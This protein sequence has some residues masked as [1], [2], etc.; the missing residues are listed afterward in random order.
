MLGQELVNESERP[1]RTAHP[2]WRRRLPRLAG[3][4]GRSAGQPEAFPSCLSWKSPW[5]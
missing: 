3:Q 1:D 4:R 5:G 2:A